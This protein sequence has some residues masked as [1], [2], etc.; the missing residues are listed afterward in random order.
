MNE[1]E[2]RMRAFGKMILS[3]LP[4]TPNKEQNLL[5][6]AL[7]F[8]CTAS[9]DDSVMLINGYAGTGKTS[10]T[11]A[12][13]K[14]LADERRK[15]VLLAPTGRAAKVFSEYSGHS[16][17]TIHRKIYRQKS[18]SPEYGNFQLAE[19][20]HTDTFFIV[21]EASM[22][23]NSSTE[24]AAFGT[25]CLLDDLIHYV[26]SGVRC[27]LIL[28]GDN[29]QLPPV[30]FADS[31]A[32]SIEQLRSYGL[33]V[34]VQYLTQTARQA[35]ESGILHNAT[36]LRCNMEQKVLAKPILHLAGCE[37]VEVLSSEYLI[38]KISDC[39]DHDGLNET[40]VITRSNKRATM[41]NA[42][43][44]NQILYREDELVS[45]DMLLVA[46]NNYYWSE[47]YEELDFIA[48]GDV[49]RVSRVRGETKAYGFRFADVT[50]E[51]P[52]HNVE[53]DAKVILDGLF[54]DSPALN[55]EQNE[56]LFTEIYMELEG[57]KRTRY[58]ALKQNPF[59]NALQ[60]KYA[61]TVTCHKAQGGQ[62]SNVFIDM[63]YIPEEAFTSLDFYRWLYTAITRARKR[64][65][66]INYPLRYE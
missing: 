11:G 41:F 63:G 40:I 32:L 34:Y 35:E 23:P 60:V 31:P 64:V 25:G 51:F 36:I 52:D 16:A 17:Y 24:G 8:F 56:R 46:K 18:Y 26:Y 57:D 44:R 43:I 13:V 2:D 4:Y 5:I 58:K 19:N 30:G 47:A 29:A 6:A 48:N 50:L 21:D 62:W 28:L 1:K 14:A 59:Y 42:G 10:L 55:R 53:V 65:Y 61:Y 9:E 3:H 45:G 7:S 15:A 49:A 38:E 27:R 22:I 33:K 37:D 20:K 39:Y 12:L 66:L 54:S